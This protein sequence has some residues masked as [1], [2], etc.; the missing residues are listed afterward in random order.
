MDAWIDIRR[1][2]RECHEA[3]FAAAKGDRRARA[4]ADAALALDDL[5]IRYY[6]PGSIVNEGVFG[7]LDRASL[8]VNIARHQDPPDEVV[9]IGH[10]IGHFKLHQDP[11]SEVTVRSSVLGGDISET[12]AG[13]VEG[14]SPRERKEIQADVFAGEFFCPSDWLR[15][16]FVARGKRPNQVAAELGL[17]PALVLNQFVR[18]LLLP[19]L[20]PAGAEPPAVDRGLDESQRVAATW[21]DGPLLVDAGPGTGKTRTLVRRIAHLLGQGVPPASILALTFSNKAANEMRERLSALNPDAA[22]EM[23]VGTFHAFGLE[24]VRKWPS[25]LGRT[26]KVR[27]LDEAGSLALLEDN[28]EKLP[29][30]HFLN[31]Y[32]P[33]LDLASVLRAISRCKDELISPECY[34]AEAAAALAAA[35]TEEQQLNAEK[36]VEVAEIYRLYEDEL[37][38][39]DA[40]D[41][42]DLVLLAVKLVEENPEVRTHVAGFKHVLVDEYQDV[43]L[44]SSRLLRA[45]CGAGGRAWV[46]ADQ[47]QSI[48]RFRGAEPTNVSRFAGEFSGTRH[49]LKINYRSHGPIVRT[50]EAFS[51]SMGSKGSMTGSWTADRGEG[52]AVTLTVA[53][54]VT[55]EAEAI[56]D[57]IEAFR[58]AGVPYGQQAIL[59]RTHLTLARITG[60]LERLG[61]PL[62]YLGDLFERDGIRTLLS[63]VALDAEYGGIGLVRV[64]ALPQYAATRADALAVIR[65]SKTQR[66]GVFDALERL[67]EIEGVSDAGRVGLAKLAKELAGLKYASPW[68]L[69]TTWLFERSDYLRPLVTSGDITARQDLV[70]IYHLLKACVEQFTLGDFSRKAFVDRIRRI[71]ALNQDS[72]YRAV[73]SE[74]AGMDAVSVMTVHGS[75]G[76][77]FRAVH[78]PALATRYMPTSRQGTRCPPPPSLARLASRPEDHDAEEQCLFFVALS[79]ARDYL[80]LSRAEQYTQQKSTASKFLASIP[81]AVPATRYAGS[82]ASFSLPVV[83]APPAPCARYEERHLSLYL[84]CPARY[85]YEVTEGLYG[86]R[87][88]SPYI[89]F[90]RCVYGT[91]EWL[92]QQ[93]E[94]GQPADAPA[95]L[96]RLSADWAEK[97]PVG[98]AFEAFYRAAAD[99]MVTGM[100]TAIAGETAQ[101]DRPEWAVPVG[102]RLVGVS[103]DRVVRTEDG[104]VHVQRVRTG[105]ET[106][107]E[108]EKPIY[109]LLRRGAESHYAG[110]RV[111][112]ETFYLA[113]GKRVAVA[114]ADDE[115]L[116]AEYAAAIAGIEE[117][118]F[119][120]KPSARTCPKC[121]CYF[122]CQG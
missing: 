32:D 102:G 105:R 38:R 36:A 51:A 122:A 85:R 114:P 97:G 6:E 54:S 43:N 111:V 73:A 26:G 41:Y 40:V 59:A 68:A 61:V 33:A 48:Y 46:V 52:G 80:S 28:L 34:L 91:V 63:L 116:L 120:P 20:R 53:P 78:L 89:Q 10:E 77:E 107:S 94:L 17:P 50:F 103:P 106:K 67:G 79:R 96:S 83:H 92:E 18:A 90:H 3:A 19:P 65:W 66:V 75:K 64:A 9:V 27:V 98:H 37:R 112:V 69:L 14:Y 86:S 35:T 113:T 108:S 109:A 4:L 58:A 56:R 45:V 55:A 119:E 30:G 29:L 24:L 47:R 101:Y 44:A 15:E 121:Q 13:R 31:L 7:F 42:G 11:T 21:D 39:A 8:L 1:K 70:A 25:G 118:R 2:A 5:E 12:G 87:D 62:L 74:A 95:A 100:A 117:G 23:W 82:G 84:Q 76:L 71:E 99:A 104:V 81:S 72:T 16:E 22:I 115:A 88:E 93:R 60:V 49:S 57:K 110:K